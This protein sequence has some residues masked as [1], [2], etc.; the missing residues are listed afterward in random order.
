MYNNIAKMAP[1]K[2]QKYT[3]VDKCSL[4]CGIHLTLATQIVHNSL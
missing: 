2:E 4:K 1:N 3:F